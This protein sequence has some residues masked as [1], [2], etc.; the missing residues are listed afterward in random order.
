MRFIRQN[1]FLI[2]LVSA[3]LISTGTIVLI[4]SGVSGDIQEALARRQDLAGKLQGLLRGKP[5]NAGMVEAEARRVRDIKSAAK[6]VLQHSVEWN[7][8]NF[9]VLSFWAGEGSERKEYKAFPFKG[10]VYRTIGTFNVTEQFVKEFE[11]LRQSLEPTAPPT[12]TEIGEEVKQFERQY[13]EEEMIASSKRAAST[14]PSAT[15]TSRKAGDLAL[16]AEAVWKA[17]A[18]KEGGTKAVLQKS[19]A[20]MMYVSKEAFDKCV[21]AEWPVN[22]VHRT[23]LWRAQVTLWVASDLV[24]ALNDTNAQALQVPGGA[25]KS[26]WV[27]NAAIKQLDKLTVANQYYLGGGAP[28]AGGA[29]SGLPGLAMG[30]GAPAAGPETAGLSLAGPALSQRVTG[31]E[32]S[33]VRYELTL[34]MPTRNLTALERNLALRNYHTILNVEVQ[35]LGNPGRYYY[36]PEP[37]S[38]VVLLGEI[39]LLAGWE[40]LDSPVEVLLALPAGARSAG[41]QQRIQKENTN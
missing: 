39:L 7:K 28:A 24:K 16:T 9:Q 1:L 12:D 4:D 23:D 18:Q 20:G 32:Y 27:E 40:R 35:P 38:R 5:V 14:A 30:G 8:R 31:P 33:V 29:P 17:R 22:G 41:D 2:V 34:V 11:K 15:E 25:A 6:T 3:T 13:Q 21:P 37:V 36:G 26:R 10:D 19:H